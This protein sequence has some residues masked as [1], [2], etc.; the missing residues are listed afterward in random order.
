MNLVK[1][2]MITTIITFG[3]C[4][5]TH[6]G[7]KILPN[8]ISAIFFP[9]NESIWEHMKLL[10][11]AIIINGLID[12]LIMKKFKIHSNNFLFN[13][14]ITSFI[15][16]PIFLILYLPFYYKIKVTMI[17][18]LTILFITIMI[19]QIISYYIQKRN[20]IDNL[21]IISILFIIIIYIIFGYL[22]YHPI[23]CDLFLDK[24]NEKYGLNIYRLTS[25]VPNR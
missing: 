17:F 20:N 21:N 4:F 15:S 3:L 11:T 8:F 9:V 1:S 16:I 25:Q 22:T 23:K 5:I 18:D 13:L 6:F 24:M 7:Y 2:K 10:Y 19:T 12:F 14:F